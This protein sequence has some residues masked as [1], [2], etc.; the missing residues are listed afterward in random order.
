MARPKSA[1]TGVESMRSVVV[2][3]PESA[4]LKLVAEAKKS[5]VGGGSDVHFLLSWLAVAYA[6]GRAHVESVEAAE[7][8]GKPALRSVS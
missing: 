3:M 7:P 1:A 5:Q 2:S 4:L 6:E 8:V